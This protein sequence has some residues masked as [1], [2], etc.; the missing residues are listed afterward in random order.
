VFNSTFHSKR[1]VFAG[2][3]PS[4]QEQAVAQRLEREGRKA[5]AMRLRWGMDRRT[6][7]R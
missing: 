5:D 2:I 1:F 4:K 6:V 7:L 3:T